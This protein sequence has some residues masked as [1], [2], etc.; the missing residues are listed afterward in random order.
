MGEG[1]EKGREELSEK[2]GGGD[3]RK[4]REKEEEERNVIM[5]SKGKWRVGKIQT[6]RR[7]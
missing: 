4:Q 6:K 5:R 3:G 2:E 1:K 7:G